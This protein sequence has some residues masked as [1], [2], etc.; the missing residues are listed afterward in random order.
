LKWK[1]VTDLPDFVYFNHQIHVKQGVGCATCHGP[2][3]KMPLITQATSMLMEWC[4]ECHRAPEKFLR[5]RAEVFNMAYEAPANQIEL[6]LRLK[7]E[8]NVAGIEHMTS[9]SVCHR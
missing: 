5:P 6:G 3:D 8:Y 7:K 4:L 2:V 1:R 9:C